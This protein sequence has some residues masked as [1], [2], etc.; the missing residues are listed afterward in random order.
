MITDDEK[1][2]ERCPSFPCWF[3]VDHRVL[4]FYRLLLGGVCLV[5][6]LF[7]L[8]YVD[9]FFSRYGMVYPVFN[10][11]LYRLGDSP[12]WIYTLFGLHLLVA[13]LLLLGWYTKTATVL[14]W[15]LFLCLLHGNPALAH[16]GDLLLTALLFWSLFV[17]AG[18]RY[19]VDSLLRSSSAPSPPVSVS[20]GSVALILQ[21][22]LVYVFSGLLKI[23]EADWLTNPL[24]LYHALYPSVTTRVGQWLLEVLPPAGM[25]AVNYLV[26]GT[27]LLV[28]LAM[29]FPFVVWLG[30][31]KSCR[32]LG[33]TRVIAVLVLAL[34]QL[35]VGLVAM[36][37][38][39]PAISIVAMVPLLP[40]SVGEALDDLAF[41]PRKD[42]KSP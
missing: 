25:Q 24:A 2:V 3:G 11:S 16:K 13:L 8:P 12:V 9:D 38:L 26:L 21:M 1:T 5:D 40:R 18:E 27:E 33:W 14:T 36:V 32:A 35:C 28:P 22:P 7:F 30:P 17:P 41:G 31:R 37:G 23:L 29:F 34:F 10:P 39:F 6:L 42:T 20:A 19:S 15:M 4:G